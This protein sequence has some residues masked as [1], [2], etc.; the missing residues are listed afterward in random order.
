M[1]EISRRNLLRKTAVA[2]GPALVSA[3]GQNNKLKV[4]VIGMGG[5][6]YYLMERLYVGS[7]DQVEV[8]HVCDTFQGHLLQVCADGNKL[9]VQIENC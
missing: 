8:G 4:G 6:G 3:L 1:S 7:K 2:A 5:R 9:L